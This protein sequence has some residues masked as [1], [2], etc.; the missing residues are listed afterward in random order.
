MVVHLRMVFV[1][2]LL[3]LASLAFVWLLSTEEQRLEY[4]VVLGLLDEE[5]NVPPQLEP[6]IPSIDPVIPPNPEYRLNVQH[7]RTSRYQ[8]APETRAITDIEKQSQIYKWT[9]ENGRVH[10]SDR[11]PESLKTAEA[12][13]DL[14][15]K[16]QSKAQYFRVKIDVL[17]KQVPAW[18]QDRLAG[19]TRQIFTILSDQLNIKELRQVG[20][21]VKV[22]D[23]RWAYQGFADKA[24]GGVGKWS[25]GFYHSGINTAAVLHQG[26][27]EFTHQVALHEST[28][29]I[30]AGLFGRMPTWFT[31]GMS[32]YF[33]HLKITGQ[34]KT[35]HPDRQQMALLQNR[36]L[37]YLG[38]WFSRVEGWYEDDQRTM[39][40]AIAWSVV[41]FLMQKEERRKLLSGY[42]KAMGKDLCHS[43]HAVGYFS[44][45]YPGGI[46]QMS[47]DWQSWVRSG[48]AR[49]HY[50]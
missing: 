41:H 38:S 25:A 17:G 34:G 8:C 2:I 32:E 12:L 43:V 20:L 3:T 4:R 13:E 46:E 47:N 1:L 42:M 44:Q 31:E 15:Q 10:F 39:N 37:P 22:F 45:S 6:I 11:A 30:M 33:E 49:R 40:Y 19:S 26:R 35:V 14:S 18:T 29:V 7:G 24:I 27:D 5:V 21:N 28:H 23:N 36:S 9:D 50:F 16:Y 48:K